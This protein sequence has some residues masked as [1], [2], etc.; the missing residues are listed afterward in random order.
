MK[1]FGKNV[2]KYT[3]PKYNKL[4]NFYRKEIYASLDQAPSGLMLKVWEDISTIFLYFLTKFQ[5]VHKNVRAVL[6]IS[7]YQFNFGNIAHA[8]IILAIDWEKLSEEE[9]FFV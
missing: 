3:Y 2:C 4:L 8:D 6:S 7:E 5:A 9:S 1:I